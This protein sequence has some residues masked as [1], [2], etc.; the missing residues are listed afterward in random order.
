MDALILSVCRSTNK[1]KRECGFGVQSPE[2]RR[3][4]RRQMW[5][6]AALSD[7]ATINFRTAD[8]AQTLSL[9]R[10]DFPETSRYL[11]EATGDGRGAGTPACCADTLVGV[12][13][14]LPPGTFPAGAVLCSSRRTGSPLGKSV[15]ATSVPKPPARDTQIESQKSPSAHTPPNLL[16]GISRAIPSS[17]C[18]P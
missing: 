8:V 14:F 13:V 16:R 9:R 7:R 2:P 1:Q 12:L 6:S 3:P 17:T 15:C 4:Q 10:R 11:V 18:M 5:R